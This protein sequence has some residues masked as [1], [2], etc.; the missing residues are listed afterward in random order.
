MVILLAFAASLCY[1]AGFVMQYHEAHEAPQRLFLSP[2][3]LIEL[4]RHRIWVAGIVVMLIGAG[5]QS[6]ALDSGSLAVVE[7][8][9]TTSLLFALPLSAAWRRERLQRSEWVGALLISAGLG[10]LLGVGSPTIGGSDMPA[11]QWFLVVA[12]TCGATMLMVT[13]GRNSS[14][15]SARA[16]LIGGAAGVQFGLQDVLTHYCLHV[17]SHDPA[18]LLTAWQPYLLVVSGIYGLILA[19]SAYEAGPLP[20]GLPP[21]A[22]GEPVVGM[23]IG[24]FALNERLDAS[25]GALA[26]ESAGAV[27]IILGTWLLARSPLVCGGRHPSRQAALAAVT[28]RPGRVPSQVG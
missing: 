14:R 6:W 16:A 2:R 11:Y 19:Q 22:V 17:L 21:I 18:A 3:L 8:I 10:V 1:A 7:P 25:T 12:A 24:L 15:P 13:T 28:P 27:V 23:L 5:L 20:A 4:C 26:L 9:L